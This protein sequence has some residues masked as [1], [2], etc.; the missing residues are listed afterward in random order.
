MY[1][2]TRLFIT[3][4][5]RALRPGELERLGLC[6]P[7]MLE[8]C[9]ALDDPLYYI[10]GYESAGRKGGWG[11]YLPVTRSLVSHRRNVR[12]SVRRLIRRFR[13]LAP[14]RALKYTVHNRGCIIVVCLLFTKSI[15]AVQLWDSRD[16][17]QRDSPLGTF[18]RKKMPL[19]QETKR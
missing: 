7:S 14:P 4:R 18:A 9:V 1:R 15:P 12:D 2:H 11:Y 5:T 17:Q 10:P 13:S 19:D 8:R 6:A 16:I 3:G